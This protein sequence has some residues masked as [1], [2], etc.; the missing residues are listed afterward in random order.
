MKAM[1]IIIGIVIALAVVLAIAI[2]IGLKNL[3]SLVEMAIESVGADVTKTVVAVDQVNIELTEGRGEIHGIAVKNPAGYSSENAIHLGQIL[4]QIEPASL[5][6]DVVVI[7][8]LTVDGATLTAEHKGLADINLQQI[9]DNIT[10]DSGK[11]P[12]ESAPTT[13]RPDIR[14]MLE[15]VSFTNMSLDLLSSEF[16]E[17]QLAMEDIY[18]TNLGDRQTGLSAEE[19]ANVLL[20]PVVD[21][22]RKKVNNELRKEAKDKLQENL[23]ENLSDDDKQKL[24]RLKSWLDK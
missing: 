10:A 12:K 9:Y 3:D 21:A 16:G 2:F 4:L 1:K 8:E 7:K 23:E 11:A 24:D 6:D 22:A 18:L 15:K 13:A 5:A 20:T 17:R 19:L 14:F